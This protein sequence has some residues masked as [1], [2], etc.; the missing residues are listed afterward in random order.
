M[1]YDAARQRVV[2]FG[3]YGL[4]DTWEWDGTT[5]VQRNPVTNPGWRRY[6]AMAYHE[7]RR[8]VVLTGD[9]LAGDTWEWDGTDWQQVS[10]RGGMGAMAY[11]AARQRVVLFG[12]GTMLYGSLVPAVAQPIGRACAGIN[13]P[14]AIASSLPFLG[15]AALVLNLAAARSSA[16]CVFL[17][18]ADTQALQLGGGCTLYVKGAMVPIFTATSAVG[19]AS[20]KLAIP[21]D[22]ALR[23][24]P[25]YAQG[26]VLDP[27]GPF[28]GLAFSGGVKLVLGD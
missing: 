1:A 8:R 14:P 16:P 18:A 5:W 13:G 28:A 24:M 7:A 15:N 10:S 3:G 12:L 25:A 4:A 9:F 19:F 23:G 21:L 6:H 27:M 17:L 22:V 26:V 11:D 20:I 2:L